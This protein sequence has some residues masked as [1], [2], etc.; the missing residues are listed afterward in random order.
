MTRTTRATRFAGLLLLPLLALG[1]AAC[2]NPVEADAHAEGLVVLDLAGNEVARYMVADGAATGMLDLGV[3][4]SATFTV[5]AVTEDGDTFE[6]DGDEFAIQL[7]VVRPGWTATVTGT[8]QVVLTATA[9]GTTPLV[10]TL[11]HGGHEE[12]VATFQVAAG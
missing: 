7:G 1:L 11:F 6:I 5:H 10:I 2:D 3:Q 9:A 8:N 4:S 12:F